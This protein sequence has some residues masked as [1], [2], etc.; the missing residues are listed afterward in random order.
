MPWSSLVPL[1]MVALITA[2]AAWPYSAENVLV[3]T[4]NSCTASTEGVSAMP[5]RPIEPAFDTVL[6]ST[7][8]SVT[9]LAEKRPPPAINGRFE[10][11]PNIGVV[12]PESNPRAK[13]LRPLSG[14]SRIFLFSITWPSDDVSASSDDA[15]SFTSTSSRTSPGCRVTR[16]DAV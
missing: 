5:L 1:L 13:A 2:P 14:S 8:S 15:T 4:L 7:P 16:I 6:L 10:P 12:L 9:S 11:M 3:F